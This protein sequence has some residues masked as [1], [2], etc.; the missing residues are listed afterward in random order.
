M[1][2]KRPHTQARPGAPRDNQNRTGKRLVGHERQHLSL[3]GFLVDALCA[4]L[5]WHGQ[6]ESVSA[7][8]QHALD[9]I[10]AHLRQSQEQGAPIIL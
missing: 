6:E 3:S 5:A 8:R 2:S 1:S 9:I 4:D 10:L 7:A